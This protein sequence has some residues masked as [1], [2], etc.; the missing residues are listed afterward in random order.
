[1]I[2]LMKAVDAVRWADAANIVIMLV[3]DG[4][5][6]ITETIK[7]TD[8]SLNMKGILLENKQTEEIISLPSEIQ[9]QQPD[10]QEYQ[11]KQPDHQEYQ[12]KQPG[13]SAVEQY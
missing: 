13:L 2:S 9:T 1:M 11:K 5:V 3:E 4:S 8:K 12:K 7:N 10:H 6:K